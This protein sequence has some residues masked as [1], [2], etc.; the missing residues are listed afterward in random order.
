MAPSGPGSCRSWNEQPPS[1]EE[2]VHEYYVRAGCYA[3]L[4]LAEETAREFQAQLQHRNQT[5]F[6]GIAGGRPRLPFCVAAAPGMWRWGWAG[7]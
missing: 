4:A 2:A 7:T 3:D 6:E 1:V 5:F